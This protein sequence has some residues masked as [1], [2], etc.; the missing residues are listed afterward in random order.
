MNTKQIN[1]ELK[2]HLEEEDVMT[3]SELYSDIKM[4][5]STLQKGL[6]MLVAEDENFEEPIK[7]FSAVANDLVYT[8]NKF[9]ADMNKVL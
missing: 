7:Y 3:V 4:Y 5:I 1:E 9:K 8:V 2:K 6:D